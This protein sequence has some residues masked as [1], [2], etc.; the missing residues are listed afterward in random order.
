MLLGKQLL[1]AVNTQLLINDDGPGIPPAL[2]EDIFFPTI[3]GHAQGTGLGL[4]IAQSIVN[5]HGGLIECE[6]QP[7]ETVFT[8]LLPLERADD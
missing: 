6:S 5:Q 7:G 4:S 2:Q 3:S 1:L 8:L